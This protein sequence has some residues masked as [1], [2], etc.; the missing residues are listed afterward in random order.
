M[1]YRHQSL[2]RRIVVA[3]T[4]LL[5]F[6]QASCATLQV[7]SLKPGSGDTGSEDG[8]S[9]GTGRSYTGPVVGVAL[10]VVVG[11]YLIYRAV[12]GGPEE[13]AGTGEV[14][15]QHSLTLPTR[16]LVVN[17]FNSRIERPLLFVPPTLTEGFWLLPLEEPAEAGRGKAP[18]TNRLRHDR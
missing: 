8:A 6:T 14:D 3:L 15:P 9:G 7:S 5:F 16:G 13:G 2:T 17:P 12:T 11:G 18:V 1:Q 10:L 4:C